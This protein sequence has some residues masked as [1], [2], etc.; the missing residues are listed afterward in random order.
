[1]QIKNSVAIVTGGA[2]GLGKETAIHLA[3][4]GAKVVIFDLNIEAAN[5]VAME[6]DGLAIETNICDDES[7]TASL[8]R[9]KEHFDCPRILVNCAGI[10][11]ASRVVGRDG[12]MQ[13]NVFKKVIEVNLIGTFN[14]IR[15]V[16]ALMSE[17]APLEDNE[18]G[19][20]VSTASVAAYDG[21]IGQAAYS[22]SKGGIISMM[23]PIAREFARF[24]IRLNTIAPGIFHTP[25]LGT[26]PKEAQESLAS[27]IP[28]PSRLGKPEEFSAL[29]ETC[30]TNRYINAETIR[31]DGGVRLTPR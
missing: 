30:I 10:G 24:G 16:G 7:V 29:V 27:N 3:K 1:M 12:P 26:L 21:Q 6:I 15:L 4:L 5:E 28:F 2:S 18:R 20:I 31:I 19:V 25:L 23:L 9:L 8:L 11:T 22:A 13:L 14:M 17:E